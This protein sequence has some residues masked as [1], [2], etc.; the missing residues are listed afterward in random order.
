MISKKKDN[1]TIL[2]DEKDDACRFAQFLEGIFEQF[3]QENIVLDLLDFKNLTLD[4]LL[5]FLKISNEHRA[6]KQSFVIVNDA[7]NP[8]QI[9]A[10]IMVVPT[11]QEAED[12][13]EMEEIERDLGF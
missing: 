3:H 13:I 1:L 5:C 9:P 12:M 11:L 10:E 6:R 2:K 4:Q 7:L 8:D